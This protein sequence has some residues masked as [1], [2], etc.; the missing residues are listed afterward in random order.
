MDF[1][2]CENGLECLLKM[3]KQD[4]SLNELSQ[5]LSFLREYFSVPVCSIHEPN[6]LITLKHKM[7]WQP[8]DCCKL[9]KPINKFLL[10]LEAKG[11]LGYIRCIN[12]AI[13]I[14]DISNCIK[15]KCAG[16]TKND[17]VDRFV[18]WSENDKEALS[19]CHRIKVHDLRNFEG[20]PTVTR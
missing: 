10:K 14:D 7:K 3:R 17:V 15:K 18:Q 16:T 6:F 1:S 9:T 8:N 20:S 5:F 11:S 13:Y 12:Q 2:D 19:I 4:L